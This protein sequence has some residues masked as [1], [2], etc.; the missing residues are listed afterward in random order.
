MK[1]LLTTCPFNSDTCI[2]KLTG[3]QILDALEWGARSVPGENGG[4]L[5]VSGLSYEIHTYIDSTC[6]AD[7]YSYFKGVSGERRVRNVKVGDQDLDPGK[8]YTVCS[9]EYT[10]LDHGDGFSM[11]DGCEVVAR[12]YGIDV[13]LMSDYISAS[14][15]VVGEEYADPYGQ[16]R[17]VIVEEK[18]EN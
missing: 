15:G 3:Q 6:E 14:G 8:T 18:P 9:L 13:Q 4:F 7:E 10:L 5:Q 2:V 17:I 11:F 16:G 12:N 1:D